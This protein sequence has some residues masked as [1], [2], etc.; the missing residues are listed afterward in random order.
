M[1]LLYTPLLICG[2]TD[3]L[4]ATHVS[5]LVETIIDNPKH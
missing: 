3:K 4:E 2:R 1:D 5:M